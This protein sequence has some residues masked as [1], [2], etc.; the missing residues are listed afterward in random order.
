MGHKL[1]DGWGG[2]VVD[3]LFCAVLI[4][5]AWLF[6]AS[7]WTAIVGVL[8]VHSGRLSLFGTLLQG[9]QARRSSQPGPSSTPT[10]V[11]RPS[12]VPRPPGGGLGGSGVLGI[13]FGFVAL[14]KVLLGHLRA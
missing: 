11:D 3:L 2:V 7:A 8:S 1:R 10:P 12:S 13:V 4:F 5:V 14:G 6:K 9:Q